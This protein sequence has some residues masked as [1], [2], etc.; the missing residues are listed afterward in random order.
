MNFKHPLILAS[1]SPRRQFLLHEAGFQFTVRNPDIDESYPKDMQPEH[2][3]VYLASK[4]AAVIEAKCS[5]AVIIA[6]DTIVI[7]D[8]I[9]LNKP[10]DRA[11]A[12]RMLSM[13]SGRTHQVI[14]AVCLMNNSKID[15]FDDHTMV[16][17]RKLTQAE[18]ASYVDR[19]HPMDKAG[20]YGAQD[21]LPAGMNPCS[22]EEMD[23]LIHINKPNLI[24]QSVNRTVQDSRIEMIE[25]I[26]GSYFTVMG[27]PIH[28]VYKHL[29]EF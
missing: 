9:I 22:Q 26:D 6:S 21:C 14:T 12:I 5:D 11:D 28:E 20:A 17:F 25:K 1:S 29:I 19:L 4:K 3:P 7:V 13:L 8:Q 24:D 15:A 16:T 10:F 27:L 18:I 2:V 23:F